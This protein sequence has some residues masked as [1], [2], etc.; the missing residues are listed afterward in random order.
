MVDMFLKLDGVDGESADHKH[1]GEIDLVSFSLGASQ[2][3]SSATGGGSGA[4]KVHMH[5][6]ELTH[7]VDKSSPKLMLACATGQHIK[8][9]VLSV[10]K[11]GG[12][13]QDFIILT[14]TDILVSSVNATGREGTTAV[15]HESFSLNF[16]KIVFDYKEQKADG[17]MGGTVTAGWDVKANKKV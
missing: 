3:V 15:P 5:D 11:A 2:P 8:Q 13:Q 16:S 9:G 4:G 6:L 7:K 17:S 1:K 10:R 14:L 12:E